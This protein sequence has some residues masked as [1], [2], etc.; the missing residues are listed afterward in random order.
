VVALCDQWYLI[1]GDQAWKDKAFQA[2]NKMETFDKL[3]RKGFEMALTIMH[4]YA[5]SLFS[6]VPIAFEFADRLF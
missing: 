5:V 4:E 1:Y 2:L 6:N 3:T